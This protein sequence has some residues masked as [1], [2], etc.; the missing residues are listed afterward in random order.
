MPIVGAEFKELR[1][2]R[3]MKPGGTLAAEAEV[4]GTKASRSR[5]NRGFL[6]LAITT[7]NQNG[8]ELTRTWSL[9]VP[10]RQ[11]APR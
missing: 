5:R 11:S 3:P 9:V 6:D 1:F 4:L 2:H 7:R 8:D 10:T